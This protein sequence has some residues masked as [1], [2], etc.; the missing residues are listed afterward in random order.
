MNKRIGNVLFFSASVTLLIAGFAGLARLSRCADE[1]FKWKTGQGRI[2]VMEIPQ[3]GEAQRAGLLPGDSILEMGG[4]PVRRAADVHF[5]FESR[6]SGTDIPLTVLRNSE[7][8]RLS[9]HLSRKYGN[10]FIVLNFLLGL[11]F[12]LVGVFVYMK[13]GDEKPARLFSWGA[14]ILGFTI[15]TVCEGFPY[16]RAWWEFALSALYSLLYPL[17]P[18]FTL[19]F[20]VLYPKSRPFFEKRSFFLPLLFIPSIVFLVLFGLTYTRVMIWNSFEQYRL[21]SGFYEAFRVYLAACL[22]LGVISLIHA[23]RFSESRAD[24]HKVQWIL[25][26]IVVGGFPFVFLWTLPLVLGLDPPI[27]EWVNYLFMLLIPAAFGLSIVKYHAWDIEV[28]IQRSIVYALVTAVIAAAY[29]MLAGFIGHEL[30]V[31][32]RSSGDLLIILFTLAAAAL[33]SPLRRRIQAFVDGNFYKVKYNYHLAMREFSRKLASVCSRDELTG[34]LMDKI[35][36]AVPSEKMVLYLKNSRLKRFEAAAGRNVPPNEVQ[37]LSI[38]CDGELVRFVET[39]KVPLAR[40]FRAEPEDVE[41]FP[42]GS[43]LEALGLDLLIPI[44]LQDQLAGFLGMGRKRSGDKYFR[45]DFQLLTPMAEQ[46]V[47]TLERLRLQEAV[48]LEKAEKSK[49]E[50]LNRLKSEFISHVSHELRAPL[51]SIQWSVQNL[52]DGIPEKPGEKSLNYLKEMDDCGRRLG[53]MIGN[54]LD[55]TKIEAGKI[56]L[57][58][59]AVDLRESAEKSLSMLQPLAEKKDIRFEVLIPAGFRIKADGDALR[60]ILTNLA[61]NAVKY[62]PEKSVVRI[63]AEKTGSGRIQVAVIDRGIGIPEDKQKLVFDRFER[64]KTDKTAREKGLGLGLHIVKKLVELQ[65]GKIRVESEP[66]K[67]SAFRF[68]LPGAGE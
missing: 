19:A 45:E 2:V 1:A 20:S 16:N 66:G 35:E 14:V 52:M 41:E 44:R 9:I 33:F 37:N 63:A 10:T 12:W 48:I 59:E 40:K 42:A 6:Q 8:L 11:M 54:L 65:G 34:L 22:I 68:D 43:C 31:V 29:F 26:A 13:K 5:Q 51:A 23:R 49:L 64:V 18:A 47:A 3:A 53:R 27:P 56:D 30:R 17:V 7:R 61:E 67:G 36:A 28:I 15:L 50:E 32:S 4:V 25:W 60:T 39:K 46:S 62:S 55:V 58:L 24:R 21:Y 38:E 57:Q